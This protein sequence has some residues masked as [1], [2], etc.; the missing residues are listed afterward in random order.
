[1]HGTGLREAFG[2]LGLILSVLV[3][4]FAH[5]EVYRFEDESGGVHYTNVPSDPRYQTVPGWSDRPAPS[6]PPT[7]FPTLARYGGAIRAAAERHGVDPRLVETV[8]VVESAGNPR[9]VSPK[10][11]IGLMQLMPHRAAELHVRNPFDPLQNLE[12]GVRHLRDLLARFDGDVT[13]A[14][15]AYNAGEEAVRTYRG[16][17]P[18]RETQDYVRK[19]RALYPTADVGLPPRATGSEPEAVYRR[20][21]DDGTILYTN[22]PPTP[23]PLLLQ[24]HF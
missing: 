12:G 2:G 4:G 10:G 20:V 15:A 23:T 8:I 18:Y 13:L 24:R 19:I 6:L 7:F 14:L 21:S 1:M 5:A 11:A 22:V 3:A 17:P 9:A 16:V